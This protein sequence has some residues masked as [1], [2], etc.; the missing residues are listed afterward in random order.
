M[1]EVKALDRYDASGNFY[2]RDRETASAAREDRFR[3]LKFGEIVVRDLETRK[4]LSKR[5]RFSETLSAFV[6]DTE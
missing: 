6:G 1:K 2:L 4:A 5:T 3:D